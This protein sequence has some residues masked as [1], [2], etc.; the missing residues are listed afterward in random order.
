M[1]QHRVLEC[2]GATCRRRIV[3]VVGDSDIRDSRR[4][5]RHCLRGSCRIVVRHVLLYNDGGG[6]VSRKLAYECFCLLGAWRI[7]FC[8]QFPF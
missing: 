2:L 7:D 5:G 8:G 1:G 6:N 4:A 3:M